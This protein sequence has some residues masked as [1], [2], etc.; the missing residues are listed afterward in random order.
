[1]INTDSIQSTITKI[2]HIA[3]KEKDPCTNA[4]I[5]ML[6]MKIYNL[7]M[8]MDLKPNMLKTVDSYILIFTKK[9]N[10]KTPFRRSAKTL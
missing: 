9:G 2:E 6:L 10:K 8:L 4:L 1:M 7:E 3:D 5:N